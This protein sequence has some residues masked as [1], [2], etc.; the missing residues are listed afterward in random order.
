MV[1]V[2]GQKLWT[3]VLAFPLIDCMILEPYQKK[4]SFDCVI[5]N[6]S[7]SLKFCYCKLFN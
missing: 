1:V 7:L 4:I 3:P 6:V 2:D 5:S